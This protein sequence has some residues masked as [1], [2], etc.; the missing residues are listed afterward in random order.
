MLAPVYANDFLYEGRVLRVL[1]QA[2]APYR[3]SPDAL[4]HFYLPNAHTAMIPLSNFV[5][6]SWVVADPAL[7]RYNGYPAVEITGSNAPNKRSG[8]AMTEMQKKVQSRAPHGFGYDWAGQ[9]LQELLSGAQAPMLFALSILVVYLCLAA[10]Y[11]S[12]SVPAA[13]LMSVRVG[14]IVTTV[15]ALMRALPNYVF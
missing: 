10:L 1:L 5:R 4:S 14:L 7:T 12:W 3:M 15:T 2:D 8:E 9:S 6:P 13:V 11:E